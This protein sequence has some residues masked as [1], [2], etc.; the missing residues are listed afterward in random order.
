LGSSG[1]L[2]KS[3][4]RIYHQRRRGGGIDKCQYEIQE[5]KEV[6]VWYTGPF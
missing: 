3:K 5:Q 2:L 4:T 6:P 1:I